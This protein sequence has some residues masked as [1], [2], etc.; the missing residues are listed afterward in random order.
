MLIDTKRS[1]P[2]QL[3]TIHLGNIAPAGTKGEFYFIFAP[4]PKI[5]AIQLNSGDP[6][7]TDQLHKQESKIAASV[8]FP[9]NAP[10]KLIREG[11]VMCSAYSK[12]CDLVFATSDMPV[13]RPP[14]MRQ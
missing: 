2:S 12:A 3:R 14:G 4:G 6:R 8:I 13:N 5:V 11:F 10:Q 1:E 7:L 9:E